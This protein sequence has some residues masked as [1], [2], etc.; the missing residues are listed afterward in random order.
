MR[1]PEDTLSPAV[2]SGQASIGYGNRLVSDGQ[3]TYILDLATW[4]LGLYPSYKQKDV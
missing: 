3:L 4:T 1:C 2:P